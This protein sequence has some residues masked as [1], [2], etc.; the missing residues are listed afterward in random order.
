MKRKICTHKEYNSPSELD[1]MASQC[2]YLFYTASKTGKSM[3]ASTGF[4]F[5][6]FRGACLA[7]L[8]QLAP[9]LSDSC[10]LE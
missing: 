10:W 9:A 3:N 2:D 1:R 4:I 5:E 6:D 8:S 7:Y